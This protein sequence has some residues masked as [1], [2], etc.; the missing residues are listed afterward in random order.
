MH[1]DQPDTGIARSDITGLVLAGG[2]GRRMG[3]ADKGLQLH[4]G[5][6][7]ALH[8][9]QRLQPQVGALMISANRNLHAYSAMGVPVWPD[10]QASHAGSF[11]GPLAGLLA[12]LQHCT[13]RYLAT[14]P[15]D[16]P[17]FPLDL[18]PRLAQ[19]LRAEH[20]D[21]AVAATRQGPG[22][23]TRPQPVFL[24]PVFC[25][26]ST[27]LQGS[28]AAYLHS[29]QRKAEAWTTQH[30]RATV[31]FD[32]AATFDNANTAEELQRLQC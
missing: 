2:R 21:I 19:A 15:C 7:L 22:D 5:L 28:L 9:L 6:P 18:V 17:N 3:G 14:V 32:D 13:T 12:G 25:L 26:L 27:T 29:G 30:A 23:A 24:Q 1:S 8:A 10:A 31:V 20:A 16:T 11:T 4:R